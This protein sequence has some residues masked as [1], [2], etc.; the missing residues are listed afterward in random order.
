MVTIAEQRVIPAPAAWARVGLGLVLAA[1]SAALMILAFPPYGQW[2]LIWVAMLPMLLA[3]YRVL[4]ARM[5]SL[6]SAVAIGGW[7]WG[8]FGPIFAG[9]GS[10]MEWLP[11]A[12]FLISLLTDSGLRAFHERTG[13]RFFVLNG[14]VSWVGFEMIRL[15]LPIAG[16]WGFLAHTQY[17]QTWLI[18]P[19]ATF[20]VLGLSFLIVLV[21]YALAQA[22]LGALDRRWQ[23]D[24]AAPTPAPR[25]SRRW[26]AGVGLALAAWLAY[27]QILLLQPA[28]PSVRVAAIQP[29]ASPVLSANRGQTELAQQLLERMREQTRAAAAQGA[30][31]IAWPEGAMLFDPQADDRLALRQLAQETQAHLAVGYIVPLS[32]QVFRNEATVIDPQGTFLGVFGKDHPVVFGGETSP[33]RGT[34]PVYDTALGRVGTII[35]YDLD[36]TDTARKLARQGAQLIAVPSQDWPAIANIHYTHLVFRAVESG[37]AMV[38]ADGGYDSAIIDPHGRIVRLAASPQGQEATLVADVPLGTGT[39]LATRLGDW[40]GWLTLAGMLGFMFL[41]MVLRQKK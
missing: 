5:S 22:L 18:Q 37:V 19:V 17:A 27:S 15:F 28:G 25:A 33:T 23:L 12:M 26:L 34:Y 4:P 6:A 7:G 24:P 2:Y 1:S 8:F 20:G 30:Q 9:T 11:A 35:C 40:V 36:F 32:A 14:A 21:N 29:A 38:K 10:F 3:Q 13:Y 31:L 16:S 41:P 39:T